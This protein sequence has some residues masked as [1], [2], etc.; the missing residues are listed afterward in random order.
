MK[1]QRHEAI[2]DIVRSKPV[3][4]QEMLRAL[5]L[6]KGIDVTQATLSRDIK[7]LGLIK[8]QDKYYVPEKSGFEIPQLLRDSVIGVDH[9]VNTVVF[10]CHA[11]M[12]MAACATFDHLE[13]GGVVGTLAGDDTIFILM[14]SEKE[15][16]AFAKEMQNVIFNEKKGDLNAQ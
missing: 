3:E 1:N 9:A 13:Y 6:E 14:R 12:A 5:L 11:G 10:K 8:R 7:E 2:I 16:A 15:A 4:T